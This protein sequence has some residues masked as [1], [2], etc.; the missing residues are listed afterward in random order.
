MTTTVALSRCLE[1]QLD[2]YNSR[3]HI[4][5]STWKLQIGKRR[6]DSRLQSWWCIFPWFG[7][8][9]KNSV[10]SWH[11]MNVILC[12]YVW[13]WQPL[14]DDGAFLN[15]MNAEIAVQ[16]RVEIL[17]GCTVCLSVRSCVCKSVLVRIPPDLTKFPPQ[18]YIS[19]LQIL[20]RRCLWISHWDEMAV[21]Y[22]GLLYFIFTSGTTEIITFLL[23]FQSTFGVDATVP[24]EQLRNAKLPG[25]DRNYNLH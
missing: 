7:P 3:I 9:F 24:I 21:N 4:I 2:S 19:H 16:R 17:G 6:L 25:H 23:Q 22:A 12:M 20:L 13:Q 11:A 18:I 10:T 1:K 14:Q 5:F 15:L 8:S